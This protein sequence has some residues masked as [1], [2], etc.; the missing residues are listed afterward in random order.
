MILIGD[1]SYVKKSG[2]FPDEV[3]MNMIDYV[4]K[5]EIVINL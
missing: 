3:D 4:S 2:G 1:R 5:V